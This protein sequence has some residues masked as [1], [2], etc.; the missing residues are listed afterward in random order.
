M[1]RI[2]I[3]ATNIQHRAPETPSPFPLIFR[4]NCCAY[5]H[6][7]YPVAAEV[8]LA[9]SIHPALPD[10]RYSALKHSLSSTHSPHSNPSTSHA[11]RTD[12]TNPWAKLS[13]AGHARPLGSP[14]VSTSHERSPMSWTA[15]G[16][17]HYSCRVWRSMPPAAWICSS[18]V[19]KRWCVTLCTHMASMLKMPQTS[20]DRS[21]TSLLG[22]GPTPQEVIN[23]QL[24]TCL[25]HCCARLSKLS[26][27]YPSSVMKVL[28]PSITVSPPLLFIL[29]FR[30]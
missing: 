3:P 29:R 17:T 19:R 13:P 22:P 28:T 23:G 21:A 6:S 16:S 9:Q 30:L 8:R 20:K 26:E 12:S 15:H 1:T 18:L 4:Q 5:R 27:E 7:V 10:F 24:G 2:N 14:M 11:H 25:Y